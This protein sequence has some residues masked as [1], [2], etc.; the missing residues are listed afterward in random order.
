MLI[1]G[2]LFSINQ[3]N[4]HHSL[5]LLPGL[6]RLTEQGSFRGTRNPDCICCFPLHLAN[7]KEDRSILLDEKI[8]HGAIDFINCSGYS[9]ALAFKLT[10]QSS[11]G[12]VLKSPCPSEAETFLLAGKKPHAVFK[13]CTMEC[14][15]HSACT[16]SIML[17][18]TLRGRLISSP[19]CRA[20]M[21][22]KKM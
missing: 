15:L 22:Q 3:R 17:T 13:H 19:Y 2:V 4:D 11:R 16:A 21:R 18:T 12:K 10:E 20:G 1:K 14:S 7:H 8:H 5:Q 6:K 9:G